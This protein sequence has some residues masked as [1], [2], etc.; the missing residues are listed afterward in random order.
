[1]MMRIKGGMVSTI[2]SNFKNKYRN[3]SL[4]CQYCKGKSRG[5]NS[6]E[7]INENIPV[8][9]QL[10]AL[11]ECEEFDDIRNEIDVKSDAGLVQFF[12]K[13]VKR[14]IQEGND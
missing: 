12:T 6:D 4:N 8:D 13:V 2:H 9:T 3:Q 5:Q 7:K 1:M 10:H 14:R 11:E